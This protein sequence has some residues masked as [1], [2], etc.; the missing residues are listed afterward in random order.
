MGARRG[1]PVQKFSEFLPPDALQLI[2]TR[3]SAEF[4]TVSAAGVPIDTP[5]FFFP[6]AD[7]TTL[8]IGTGVSYPAKAERA[9]RN[10]RVGMLVEGEANQP[11]ISIAG[12][13]AVQD[14]DIQANVERNLAETIFSPNVDPAVVPWEVTQQRLYYVSR[15]IVTV[16]PAHVRWWPSR[17]AMDEQPQSWRAPPD[18]V[19]PQSDAAP[20]GRPSRAP[21]W[22]ERPWAELADQALASAMPAHLTLLDAEGFPLPIRVRTVERH[23]RGFRMVVPKAAPWSEGKAT[24]SFVGKEIFVG[25]ASM[26]GKTSLLHVERALPILPM[27]ASREGISA[28]DLDALNGRLAEEMQRRGQPLPKVP[29]TP[30]PPTEGAKFRA[31]ATKAMDVKSVGGGISR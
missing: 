4:A 25:T 7:L 19:F 17:A 21:V 18:T 3:V 26:E 15:I 31:D 10:P 30:P 16:A 28:A 23:A 14:A 1:S 22:S 29:D 12:Y 6:N 8:D 27:M 2:R 13:A 5:L 24:L 20:A 11:V 9:R